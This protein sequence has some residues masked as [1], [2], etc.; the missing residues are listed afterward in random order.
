MLR[1]LK[2]SRRCDFFLESH[3]FFDSSHVG[4]SADRTPETA[5]SV[6]II[7]QATFKHSP[8]LNHRCRYI[9]LQ[10]TMATV[11]ATVTVC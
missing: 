5:V 10:V 7:Q 9:K 6:R 2:L 11:P 4:K 8:G 3:R 1:S